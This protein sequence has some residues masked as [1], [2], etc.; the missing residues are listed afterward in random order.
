MLG[1][2]RTS[3]FNSHSLGHLHFQAK[4]I[5]YNVSRHFIAEK[6]KKELSHTENLKYLRIQFGN[7]AFCMATQQLE[8]G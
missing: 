6:V 8:R 2:L 4:E 7:A 3:P 1:Q 5:I